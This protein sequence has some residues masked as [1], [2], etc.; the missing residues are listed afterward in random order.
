[1]TFLCIIIRIIRL[2]QPHWIPVFSELNNLVVH[3]SL[4]LN[5]LAGHL[6]SFVL[7][8]FFLDET[9]TKF[10]RR[11]STIPGI[12]ERVHSWIFNSLTG[13]SNMN[14]INTAAFC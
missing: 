10:G 5:I 11:Y 4:E 14:G 13:Y 8:I 3:N 7:T 2:C 9:L 1:M 12:W 6:Y